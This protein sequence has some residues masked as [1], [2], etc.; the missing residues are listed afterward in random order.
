LTWH[1]YANCIVSEISNFDIY[2]RAVLTM[3]YK[4]R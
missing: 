1:E 2:A 4:H 3:V